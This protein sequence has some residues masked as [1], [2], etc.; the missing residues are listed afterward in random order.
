MNQIQKTARILQDVSG[1]RGA[2][3]RTETEQTSRTEQDRRV[4]TELYDPRLRLSAVEQSIA[5]SSKLDRTIRSYR[6]EGFWVRVDS[7]GRIAGTLGRRIS[8]SR[9]VMNG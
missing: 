9:N 7:C 1:N 3:P 6:R 4:A 2:H 5:F 8:S